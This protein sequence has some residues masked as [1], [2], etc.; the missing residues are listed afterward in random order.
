[1]RPLTLNTS[2]LLN[3]SVIETREALRQAIEAGN[4]SAARRVVHEEIGPQFWA[5]HPEAL[6][7]LLLQVLYISSVLPILGLF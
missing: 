4:M 3:A 6:F 1:M 5:E 7:R 2:D